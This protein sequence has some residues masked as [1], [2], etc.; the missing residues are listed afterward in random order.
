LH[1][2]TAPN[3][4]EV[5]EDDEE[6][7]LDSGASTPA[8]QKA[9]RF[10]HECLGEYDDVGVPAL[11]TNSQPPFDP[12]EP[13]RSPYDEPTVV[14]WNDPS[15]EMFPTDRA[16]IIHTIRRLSERLPEDVPNPEIVPP[17]PVIGPNGQLIE[18]HWPSPSPIVL[19]HQNSPSLDS[20]T[21]EN[22]EHH[23][24]LGSNPEVFK[25][26]S[27]SSEKVGMGLSRGLNGNILAVNGVENDKLDATHEAVEPESTKSVDVESEN[28]AV[29][30]NVEAEEQ[31]TGNDNESKEIK[32]ENVA[33]ESR[34]P[35]P[36]GV[37]QNK[38]EELTIQKTE[39]ASTIEPVQGSGEPELTSSEDQTEEK[40]R[41]AENISSDFKEIGPES[42]PA[43]PV[44]KIMAQDPQVPSLATPIVIGNRQLGHDE[45]E[46]QEITTAGDNPN[47]TVHPATPAAST[48]EF[49]PRP[50]D[51]AIEE[52]N[53]RTIKSRKNPRS[54]SRERPVTPSSLHSTTRD[55]KSKNFL[56][57]FW[58][59]LFVDWIGGLIRSL[60]GGRGRNT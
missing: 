39:E 24:I 38:V 32:S 18:R 12:L 3:V 5:T 10:S 6:D 59:V 17:S 2:E 46:I 34:E 13:V 16:S 19:A 45:E 8:S 26:P 7:H 15:L 30:P 22:D 4:P 48:V 58:R 56:K 43:E 47:I 23:D 1:L 27:N 50:L 40:P 36:S 14:D 53:G 9:P 51:T 35:E 31:A 33:D 57:A 44:E 49:I 52:E 54:Q 37:A 20:I 41:V 11:P 60:C 25:L 42:P 55:T 28:I 29:Q 21:E